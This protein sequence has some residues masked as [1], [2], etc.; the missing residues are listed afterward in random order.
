[1]GASKIKL[2]RLKHLRPGTRVIDSERVPAGTC[3]AV[4]G[5]D[6]SEALCGASVAEVLEENFNSDRELER[7]DECVTLASQG[8]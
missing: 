6:D 5:L 8:A 3:H 1:M 7:C 2:V 4:A